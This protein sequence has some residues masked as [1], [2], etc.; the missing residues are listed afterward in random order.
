LENSRTIIQIQLIENKTEIDKMTI[1]CQSPGKENYERGG[2]L[3]PLDRT[4]RS[5]WE[6]AVIIY[7]DDLKQ[8]ISNEK[9]PGTLLKKSRVNGLRSLGRS[10]LIS[11]VISTECSLSLLA[12]NNSGKSGVPQILC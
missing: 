1:K 12:Y 9:G 10:G 7:L 5:V 11:F 6:L 3:R 8:F 2:A 4:N